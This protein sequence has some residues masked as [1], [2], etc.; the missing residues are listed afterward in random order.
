MKC[1]AS[2]LIGLLVLIAVTNAALETHLCVDLSKE[3]PC[4]GWPAGLYPVCFGCGIGFFAECQGNEATILNCPTVQDA[5]GYPSILLFD[6]VTKTCV[7][8]TDSCP[9]K[10]PFVNMA[11]IEPCESFPDGKYH[12]CN[13]DCELGYFAECQDKKDI[14][15]KRCAHVDDGNGGYFRLRLDVL[16]QSCVEE[17]TS[18]AIHNWH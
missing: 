8:K 7:E 5:S 10:K 15:I 3:T 11:D 14:T 18:C 9:E 16:S 4:N 6:N 2:L 13:N 1:L 17:S 12:L